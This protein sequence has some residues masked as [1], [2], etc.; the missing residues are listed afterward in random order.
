MKR[1]QDLALVSKPTRP[2][3]ALLLFVEHPHSSIWR[4]GAG[5]LGRAVFHHHLRF[6]LGWDDGILFAVGVI[7]SLGLLQV[8]SLARAEIDSKAILSEL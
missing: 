4:L 6:L 7:K 3:F 2:L 8:F 1:S 5:F